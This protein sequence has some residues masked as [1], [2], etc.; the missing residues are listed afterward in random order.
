MKLK[1]LTILVIALALA[2]SPVYAKNKNKGKGKGNKQLPPGLAM[3]AQRGK[4]LPP[5]WQKKISP[6]KIIDKDIYMHGKIIAP[7]DPLGI[8]TIKIDD[9]IMR[10]HKKNMEILEILTD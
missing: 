4:P 8:V 3:N 6:G 2:I 9:K 7:L 1:I 5:G 10:I